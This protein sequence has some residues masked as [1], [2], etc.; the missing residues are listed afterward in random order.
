V[1]TLA[2]FQDAFAGALLGDVPRDAA[3]ARLAAQPGFAVYRNTVLKGGIDA[4]QANFPSV[5][6]LVGGEWFRAAA[7]VF[8]RSELPAHPT[9]LDYGAGFPAFLRDFAPAAGLPYLADVARLDRMWNEA[10][11][12]ADAKP[13]EPARLAA[14]DP[15]RMARTRLRPHPATR[16]RWFKSV[17]A[18]T[19]WSR[20]RAG[21]GEVGE[22]E[23][24][25]EGALLTRPFGEVRH[26][27]LDRVGVTFLDACARG[28]GIEEA[29]VAALAAGAPADLSALVRRLLEAGA[30]AALESIDD[31]EGSR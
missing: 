22:V 15:Q 28:A 14:L 23:W 11:V 18:Y 19:L 1:T 31:P 21:E 9:L 24:Q 17:P 27:T 5:A 7:A 4:L 16:W 10:H 25:G 30:F 26:A 3:V 6:R 8:V 12:A 13:L 29:A 2:A 20:S